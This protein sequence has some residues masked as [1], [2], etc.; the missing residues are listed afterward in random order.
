MI[1]LVRI[2]LGKRER[3]TSLVSVVRNSMT[4]ISWFEADDWAAALLDR[5][6][7]AFSKLNSMSVEANQVILE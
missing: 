1:R 4:F 7:L 6:D 3:T 2:K 5:L